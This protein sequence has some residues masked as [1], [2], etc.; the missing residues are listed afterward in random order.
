MRVQH[1]VLP[2]GMQNAEEPNLSA[3]VLWIS[4]NFEQ[5][6]RSRREQKVVKQ[7]WIGTNQRIQLM[8]ERKHDVK[9]ADIQQLL[10][11]R[12]EPV[13][14]CL[15]LALGAMPIA[16]GVI[17]DGLVSATRTRIEMAAQCRRAAA[18]DSPQHIQLL[19]ADSGRCE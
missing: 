8:R 17:R 13:L 3:E 19:I 7:G 18:G 14:A 4:C 1:Q 10:F 5:C 9:I 15:R 2:P 16:A 6:L 11:S 12:G